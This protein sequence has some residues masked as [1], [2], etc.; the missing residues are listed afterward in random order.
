[1]KRIMQAFSLSLIVIMLLALCACGNEGD[2]GNPAASADDAAIVEADADGQ[3]PVMNFIGDYQCDRAHALVECV[4]KDS[5]LIT[6]DWGGSAWELA[7]WVIVGPLDLDTLTIEYSGC[8]KSI[9]TYNDEGELVSEEVEYDDGTG[10]IIFNDDGTFTWH[11]DQSE[12]GQDMLFEW[13]PVA[14]D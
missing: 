7:R 3:N 10:T 1:M 14:A 6:I 8:T 4:D 2:A 5:A 12:Y 9:L 13:V 11:E